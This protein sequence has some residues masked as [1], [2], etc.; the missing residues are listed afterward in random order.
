MIPEEVSEELEYQHYKVVGRH[1]AVKICHWTRKSIRDEGHCYK[2][3]F[4]GIQSHRCLQMTPS[5]LWCTNQCVYCWRTTDFTLKKELEEF[6]EPQYI[7]EE[8]VRQQ[9]RLLSGFGGIPEQ[10]NKKKFEEAQKPNQA[11][12]SLAG[13]P[14][15]YP[16]L[17]DLLGEFHKRSY[18]TYL[19]TNG[20]LPERLEALDTLPTQL[21]VSLDAPTEGIYKNVDRPMLSDAWERVNRTLE[22]FPSLETR[23]VVRLTLVK[24]LNMTEPEAYSKL[25]LKAEPDYVEVKAYMFVGGSRQRLA[26]ENMP[27]HAEIE[28]FAE[29]ISDNTGYGVKDRKEDS[30]VML[31]TK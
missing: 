21:Y 2:Q 23:K 16:R 22:L 28:E 31:L 11:A 3:Q 26:L 8:A 24:G 13:E 20:T 14:T 6:D 1:S 7:I 10:I 4:Y 27:S 25:I 29:K 19:V 12:I 17:S 30:R 9:R 18:T 15:V 5:V